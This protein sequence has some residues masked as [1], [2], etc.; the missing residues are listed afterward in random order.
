MSLA[1][2]PAQAG[3]DP[4]TASPSPKASSTGDTTIVDVRAQLDDL[5]QQQEDLVVQKAQAQ[6]KLT[7]SKNQLTTTQTQ[8]AAQKQQLSVLKTQLGQIALQQ[9]QDRGLNTTAMI[10][11]SSTSDDLLNY[12]TAMQQVSDTTNTLFTTYQVQQ[13]TLQDLENTEQAT[14]N[15]ISEEQSSID[16]LNKQTSDKIAQTSL[17]LNSMIAIA[18]AV[19]NSLAGVD[20]VGAGV[21]DPTLKVPDPSPALKSPLISYKITSPFGMRIHPITGAYTFHDGLDMAASCGT[22]IV[23]PGNGFVMDYYWAGAYGNRLVIDNGIINGHHVVT[24]FN[25]LSGGI[26]Q[27]GTSVVQ[28]QAVALVGTT[29]ESTGCHLHYMVWSDGQ[30]EDPATY[31]G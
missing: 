1:L 9:F 25:H 3:A 16:T 13:A 29:G 17:L 15:A 18:A 10:L 11:A 27:P 14:I 31:L 26:A 12:M 2:S 28:G 4:A 6:D 22:T 20:A 7:A 21:T 30:I 19:N 8:I 23:A 24:S 5:Q